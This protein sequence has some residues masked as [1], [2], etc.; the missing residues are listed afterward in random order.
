MNDWLAGAANG[1]DI[2]A[3]RLKLV[4]GG[5][6]TEEQKKAVSTWDKCHETWAAT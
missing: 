6:G 3:E 4:A 2:W 5:G 1:R